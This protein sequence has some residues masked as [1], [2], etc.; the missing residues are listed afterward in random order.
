MCNRVSGLQLKQLEGRPVYAVGSSDDVQQ[1]SLEGSESLGG[2][3]GSL[4]VQG[5]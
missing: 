5:D 3:L 2:F 1:K 4:E